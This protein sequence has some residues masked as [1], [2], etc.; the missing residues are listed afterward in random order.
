MRHFM[1]VMAMALAVSAI[2]C[3]ENPKDYVWSSITGPTPDLQPTFSS[4]QANIF[5]ASDSSGRLACI[6]CHSNVGHPP[7]GGLIL[8]HDAAYNQLV[9]RNSVERRDLLRVAPNDADSSYLIHKLEGRAG[10]VGSRM[11]LNSPA[12]LTDGQ[13]AVIKRWIALGA[14]ND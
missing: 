10:I 5:E 9:N 8:L 11:P 2:A 7:T 6:S 14:P 13:I 3:D 4:I 1:M 12:Y